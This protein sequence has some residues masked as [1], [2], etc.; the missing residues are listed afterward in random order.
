MIKNA[1]LDTN[2]GRA[3]S[4]LS[5]MVSELVKI[6]RDEDECLED[7][8]LFH[9]PSE[10]KHDLFKRTDRL[11]RE[12]FKRYDINEHDFYYF[13]TERTSDKWVYKCLAIR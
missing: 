6:E 7:M 5:R 12:V 3:D 9:A 2:F 8:N 4:I 10:C 11:Y 13:V 1:S